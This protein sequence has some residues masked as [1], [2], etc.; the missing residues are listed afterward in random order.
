MKMPGFILVGLAFAFSVIAVCAEPVVVAGPFIPNLLD[1]NGLAVQCLAVGS[2]APFTLIGAYSTTDPVVQYQWQQQPAGTSSWINL[3]DDSVF[4]GTTTA[5]FTVSNLTLAMQGDRYR[6]VV[7]DSTGSVNS[8]PLALNVS[9]V[10]CWGDNA[11]Y[12]QCQVP[13]NL[14]DDVVAV[15]AGSNHSL[16][17]MADG[18][19]VYWGDGWDLNE[20]IPI[21]GFSGNAVAI[22]AGSESDLAILDDGTVFGW[23][24]N[25][26][27]ELNIPAGLHH[28]VAIANGGIHSLALVAN[29]TVVAWGDNTHGESSV[30]PG[31]SNVVAIASGGIHCLALKNDGTVVAWGDNAEGESN[32]P[33]GLANVVAIAAGTEFSLALKS[34]GTVVAWG[35]NLLGECTVPAGLT[36]VVAISAAGSHS[37]ALKDD[38]TIVA[39][40]DNTDDQCNIPPNLHNV[41]AIACGQAFNTVLTSPAFPQLQAQPADVALSTGKVFQVTRYGGATYQW[42]AG[43]SGDQ[44][45]PVGGAVSPWFAPAT[46]GPYWVQITTT[47]ATAS[48][49]TAMAAASPAT[50]AD[51]VAAQGLTGNDALPE[52]RLTGNSLP[53]LVLFAMNLSANPSP[54]L[55]PAYSFSFDGSELEVIFQYRQSKGLSG[56]TLIPQYSS[57]LVNWSNST[58]YINAGDL[59]QQSDDDANTSRFSGRVFYSGKQGPYFFR[60]QVVPSL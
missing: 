51:W 4:S 55:L 42:Y 30:P 60:W 9:Y 40:G 57:D 49:A 27:G 24:D 7:S 36:H 39:W 32:V 23:G 31:L 56:Y 18:N 22:A 25:T 52:T 12:N 54:S 15:S 5:N 59:V 6:C 45:N 34:D 20:A 2:N 35:D 37:L 19:I 28:V 21:P 43:Q 16:A 29:G 8:D 10:T 58:I 33:A 44:S 38:G 41:A 48:S 53:N 1:E 47:S 14:T 3:S 26:Y 46:P 13:G 17:L 50:F 11:Y